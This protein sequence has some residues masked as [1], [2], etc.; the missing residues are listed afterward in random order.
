MSKC[1][2]IGLAFILAM[3]I[4]FTGCGKHEGDLQGPA[5]SKVAPAKTPKDAVMNLVRAVEENN[6]ELFVISVTIPDRELAETA[7]ESLFAIADFVTEFEK[8]YGMAPLRRARLSKAPS[9]EEV[10]A[11]LKIEIN[12]DQATAQLSDRTPPMTLLNV[13]GDWKIDL[14]GRGPS[15]ENREQF[16]QGSRAIIKALKNGKSKIGRKDYDGKRVLR[17]TLEAIAPIDIPT[18]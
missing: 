6:K 16:L 11:N 15:P 1:T 10:E 18:D 3:G 9:Y 13:N 2:Q 5:N 14:P 17:E 7:F 4:T 8:A 12:G